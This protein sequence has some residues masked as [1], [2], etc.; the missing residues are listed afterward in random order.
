MKKLGSADTITADEARRLAL[1]IKKAI[2][3]DSLEDLFKPKSKAPT[4]REFFNDYYLPYVQTYSK[5]WKHNRSTFIH[6]ILP[7][8]GD[9]RMD[10]ITTPDIYSVINEVKVKKQL[11]NY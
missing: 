4:L 5:S 8:L 3:T 11:K 9:K 6:H 2:A 1:K 10:E 7:K